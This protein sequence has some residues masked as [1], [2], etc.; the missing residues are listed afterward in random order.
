MKLFPV[1]FFMFTSFVAR[2]P[3]ADIN[4]QHWNL[5]KEEFKKSYNDLGEETERRN[6]FEKELE[7]IEQHNELYK[8]VNTK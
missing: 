3:A 7:Y 8:Q 5:Y 6:I 2:I 4:D 1:L